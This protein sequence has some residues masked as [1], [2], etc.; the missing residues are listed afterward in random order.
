MDVELPL[1]A[2]RARGVHY[3]KVTFGDKDENE[4]FH[5]ILSALV[6]DDVK[7]C[8]VWLCIVSHQWEFTNLIRVND[9]ARIDQD[10][11]PH[12]KGKDN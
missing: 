9:I 10:W 3:S 11:M 2:M 7:L 4:T 1:A 6:L 12:R 8:T 5:K